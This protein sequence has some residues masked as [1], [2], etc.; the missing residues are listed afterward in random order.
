LTPAIL[1]RARW[2]IVIGA[3]LTGALTG[4]MREPRFG[5]GV[6][7]AGLWAFAS[8]RSLEGLLGAAV[9]PGGGARNGRAIFLWASA[10]IG[11]YAIA[12]WAL[13][14]RPFPATSLLVG[15]TW[16]PIAFVVAALLPA[17]RPG[18]DAPTRG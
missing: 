10:K 1:V 18:S 6:V 3:V 9:V 12:I 5:F 7:A 2:I 16:L 13:I 8:L 11:V 15:V 14:V 17:P 4:V